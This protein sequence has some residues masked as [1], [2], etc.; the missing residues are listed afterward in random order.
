MKFPVNFCFYVAVLFTFYSCKISYP[1][2]EYSKHNEVTESWLNF[3]SNDSLGISIDFNGR[4]RILQDFTKLTLRGKAKRLLKPVIKGLDAKLFYAS[5]TTGRYF[6]YRLYGFVPGNKDDKRYNNWN[7]KKVSRYGVPYY[8]D[9]SNIIKNGAWRLR[10]IMVKAK[11][12]NLLFVWLKEIDPAW[13]AEEIKDDDSIFI[14][15][16][17]SDF[18]TL[19]S[20]GSY[21]FR[22][23]KKD[24]LFKVI[25][26][27]VQTSE[28]IT[29]L[30]AFG[31]TN[32]DSIDNYGL[33]SFFYQMKA[34]AYSFINDLN[35]AKEANILSFSGGRRTVNTNGIDSLVFSNHVADSIAQLA[36]TAQVLMFNE[37]H[38]DWRNRWLL[39]LMLPQLKKQG[40][41]YLCMEALYSG[42]SVNNRGYPSLK[43]GLYY[44]EPFM[45]NLLRTALSLG[46]KIVAYEDTMV[47]HRTIDERERAQAKNLYNQFKRD[48]GLKWLVLAG[49]SHINKNGF[50]KGQPSMLQYFQKLCKAEIK[51]INQTKYSPLFNGDINTGYRGK[52]YFVVNDLKKKDTDADLFILSDLEK[53]P[54]E[55]SSSEK[56]MGFARYNLDRYMKSVPGS[57]DYLFVYKEEEYLKLQQ[58]AVPVFIKKIN[59]IKTDYLLLPEK[60]YLFFR[61]DNKD[62][63]KEF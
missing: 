46:F 42:D 22:K 9:S 43:D 47:S 57:L 33:T 19:S 34:T 52:G 3:Y 12:E 59:E 60:R 35:S 24:S 23:Q 39:T 51:C 13:S 15:N 56:E 2:S 27:W 16:T 54:Y 63:R 17:D 38:Y 20:D 62:I 10:P 7:V 14:I 11:D 21:K 31:N 45:G 26:G 25:D 5:K 4:Q 6:G 1:V 8:T 61:I 32:E 28:Y 37:S 30:S 29:P 53:L 48:P 41:Q 50:S 44:K 36:S 49:Y 55:D 58:N 40:Y 18:A